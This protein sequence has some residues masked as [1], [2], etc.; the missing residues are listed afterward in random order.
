MEMLYDLFDIPDNGQDPEWR[1]HLTNCPKCNTE[2]HYFLKIAAMLKANTIVKAPEEMK[3][4]ILKQ[5]ELK[6]TGGKPA[7]VISVRFLWKKLAVTAAVLILLLTIPSLFRGSAGEAKASYLVMMAI[8]SSKN[9]RNYVMHFS[10]RTGLNESFEQVDPDQPMV[11]HTLVRSFKAPDA[12]SIS[13]PGREV[14]F[15]G[16]IQYLH[17]PDAN[18]VYVGDE[19]A[20]FVSWMRL[21]L[22]PVSILWKEKDNA[23]SRGA[24]IEISKR[25]GDTRLTITT[26]AAGDFINDKLRNDNI[27]TADSRREYV[28]DDKTHLLKGLQI[29]LIVAGKQTLIFS[30]NNITYNITLKPGQLSFSIPAG[31]ELKTLRDLSPTQPGVPSGTTNKEAARMALEDLSRGDFVSHK[32]LWNEYGR[33]WLDLLSKGYKGIKVERIGEPFRSESVSGDI[34]PYEIR[35]P[36]GYI[37]RF[38]LVLDNR[39]PAKTWVVKGGL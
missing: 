10:V 21:L 7:K 27:E 38:R 19:K 14:L 22:D 35:F 11:V 6:Q 32:P 17:I 25:S 2:Y 3:E 5:V 9:I 15:D 30:I 12:W 23:E 1:E 33:I 18:I 29:F 24:K 13:K 39:N 4:E 20:G 36:N 37:K 8:D 28:F 34:V 31:A 26:K 16:K